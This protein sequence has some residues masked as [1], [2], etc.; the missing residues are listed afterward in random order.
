MKF[1]QQG[2]RGWV[3]GEL[4]A[5]ADCALGKVQIISL[6]DFIPE[7]KTK[8]VGNAQGQAAQKVVPISVS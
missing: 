7:K 8:V 2:F 1:H 6:I 4:G 3:G 5:L